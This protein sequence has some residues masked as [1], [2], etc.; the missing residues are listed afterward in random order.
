ME[1]SHGEKFEALNVY[2]SIRAYGHLA[3]A[4]PTIFALFW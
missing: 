1:V 4:K 3:G 2:N